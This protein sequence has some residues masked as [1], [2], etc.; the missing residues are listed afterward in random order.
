MAPRAHP[1]R[2]GQMRILERRR[3]MTLKASDALRLLENDVASI[4]PVLDLVAGSAAL[5]HCGVDMSS[6][7]VIGVAF[8][9]VRVLVNPRGMRPRGTQTRT[10]QAGN[11][12]AKREP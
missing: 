1:G 6:C 5:I 9:A 3:F 7:R 2:V 12:Q 8:Q 11:H 4:L 10:H